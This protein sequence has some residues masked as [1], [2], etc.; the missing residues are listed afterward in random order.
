MNVILASGN[1]GKVKEIQH[2]LGENFEIKSL[3]DFDAI[4][5]IIEDGSSFEENAKIKAKIVYDFYKIPAMGDDSGL[6]VEQ[7]NHEPGIFSARYAGDNATDEE[8]NK[9]LIKNLGKFPQ[10]HIAK[11]ICYAAYYDGKNFVVSSGEIKGKIIHE[12]R[13]KNGFGYDPLFIPDGYEKTSAELDFD[14]KNR[15]SHRYKA[16][17]SLKNLIKNKTR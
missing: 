11:F 10:P 3:I 5:E 8:N 17:S 2:I 6:V 9:K 16:F 7:L 14:E 4:P 1:K 12:P 13:G 15:I